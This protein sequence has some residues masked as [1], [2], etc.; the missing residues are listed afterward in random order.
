MEF[1]KQLLFWTSQDKLTYFYVTD[2][3][4]IFNQL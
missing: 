4:K 3:Y 1:M 2:E